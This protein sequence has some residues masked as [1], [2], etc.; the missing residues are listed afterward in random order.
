MLTEEWAETFAVMARTWERIGATGRGDVAAWDEQLTAMRAEQDRL[1]RMGRWTRGPAD[2][3]SVAGVHRRELAHSAVLR[4][5]C[6]PAGSHAL[7]AAFLEQLLGATGGVT[8]LLHDAEAATEITR[9]RSRAD[10]VIRGN[11]WTVVA[12]LKIDA[13]E[14]PDQCQR[15]YEDWRTEPQPRFVFLTLSGRPPLTATT[16]PARRAWQCLSW[17]EISQL[18]EKAVEGRPGAA[19]AVQE[20]RRTLHALIGRRLSHP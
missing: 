15:L 19:T 7:G 1:T 16:E 12:E 11:G 18:L 9:E 3:M 13:G 8:D 2:L 17:S 10:V 4:W 20:Y 5:L 14:M 6:D